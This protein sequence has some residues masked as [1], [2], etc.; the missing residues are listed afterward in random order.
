M[1]DSSDSQTYYFSNKMGR[2]VLLSLEETVGQNGLNAILNLARLQHL[3][4]NYPP[5]NFETG[6]SFE[7][8]AALLSAIDEMY[9]PRS[10]R[11]LLVRAG[12]TCFK[13]GVQDFGG[14]LGVADVTF[15]LMTLNTRV[16][17]GLEVIA[18]ILNRYSHTVVKLGEDERAY[19]W[20]LDPCGLCWRR[21]TPY[22]ACSLAV[23][24]LEEALYWVSGGRSFE[25][26]EITCV[27]MGHSA[28]TLRVGKT[29]LE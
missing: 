14:L 15:R 2:I 28:C 3:S 24:L 27:A 17:I 25:V 20:T 10:G 21:S 5:P 1:N 4:G 8:M 18:E 9:G 19:F 11:L 29:P 12:R 23:G 13:Y 22:P 7:E 6:F 16:H 26:E